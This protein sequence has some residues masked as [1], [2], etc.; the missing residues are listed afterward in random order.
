[1]EMNLEILKKFKSNENYE[2]YTYNSH[3]IF[4]SVAHFY[5]VIV[6]LTNGKTF[7]EM[8]WVTFFFNVRSGIFFPL[9]ILTIIAFTYVVMTL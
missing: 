6:A 1:M 2:I 3:C 8:F 4:G 5:N 7:Y 9:T